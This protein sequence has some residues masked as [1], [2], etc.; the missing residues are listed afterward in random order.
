MSAIRGSLYTGSWHTLPGAD[1]ST[2]WAGQQCLG[3]SIN[4]RATRFSRRVSMNGG[5]N[6]CLFRISTANLRSF[7][8]FFR[9][10]RSRG[11]K[12]FTPRKTE[13]LKK[14]NWRRSGP[15]LSPRL[16][17]TSMELLELSV[18]IDEDLLVCDDLGNLRNERKTARG[19]PVP[20]MDRSNRGLS[21]H[22][23]RTSRVRMAQ[24]LARRA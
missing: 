6:Q 23:M 11:R 17:T 24:T 21:T 12:T 19:L 3:G 1:G 22:K 8:N 9:N 16:S 2:A 10:G 7:G 5:T 14:L 15:T 4:A 13:L 18:A 20:T